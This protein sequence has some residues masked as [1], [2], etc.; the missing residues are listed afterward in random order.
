M[1]DPEVL[2]LGLDLSSQALKASLLDAR[3]RGIDEVAVRFDEDLPQFGTRGG[4]LPPGD[5]RLDVP[6]AAAAPV[7]MYVAAFDLLWERIANERGW[8]LARI[9]A[10]SAAG[11]QHASVYFSHGALDALRVADP[12]APLAPQLEDMFSRATVP[13]WQ[14]ATTLKECSMLTAAAEQALAP[15]PPPPATAPHDTPIPAICQA[16]GSIAHTRFTAAQILRWRMQRPEEY[17]AT[18]RITLVSNFVTTLLRAGFCAEYT[19]LDKSDVCGMNLWAMNESPPHWSAPLIDATGG[20]DLVARLGDPA[21]DPRTLVGHVGT[22]L[23]Q[24]YGL[25]P[26][27]IVCQATGDNPATL[28]C[29][30]PR[31]GEAVISLGT[32]DTVLLPSDT[33]VP[34]PSYHI[35]AHPA[36]VEGD[37]ATPPYFLMFVYKNASLAR[38]WV[39]DTY[40]DGHWGTFDAAVQAAAPGAAAGFYWL[41]PEIIPW[42]ARGVHRFDST[43]TQ[44]EAFPE[45]MLNAAAI[46]QSHCLAFRSRI[47]RVLNGAP[48]ERVFVVGGAAGNATLCQLLADVLDCEVARPRVEGR[49]AES[50]APVAYNFCS[51]GAAYR[52]RWVWECVQGRPTSFETCIARAREGMAAYDVVARPDANRA[53]AFAAFAPQWERL[54]QEAVARGATLT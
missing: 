39:R 42:D 26:S 52:A 51:V 22:W 29:L 44:I 41:R 43:G 49:N 27:C 36:S 35:F 31:R 13:N 21:R 8:P 33:Y 12:D 6:E 17:S 48:L 50:G 19:P 23:Q 38:E 10:I 16:T 11:Q 28:Q 45:D 24:R 40:C 3:L 15:P 14:D 2:F 34:H 4:I 37:A 7:Q 46:V 20:P 1:A 53:R 32:S 54:E 9:G 47:V 18:E 30:T 5:A 25:S